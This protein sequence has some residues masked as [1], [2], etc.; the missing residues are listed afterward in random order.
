MLDQIRANFQKHAYIVQF[1][2][3]IKKTFVVAYSDW[4]C[5][6]CVS[7]REVITHQLYLV[8]RSLD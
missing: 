8:F 6:K 7:K 1:C 2:I 3:R 5:H 4:K